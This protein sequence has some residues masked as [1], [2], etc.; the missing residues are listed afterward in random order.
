MWCYHWS[1]QQRKLT[2]R[3]SLALGQESWGLAHPLYVS[4]RVGTFFWRSCDSLNNSKSHLLSIYFTHSTNVY[5]VSIR[6]WAQQWTPQ[7]PQWQRW[8]SQTP[9]SVCCGCCLCPHARASLSHSSPLFLFNFRHAFPTSS[10]TG[11]ISFYFLRAQNQS[12]NIFLFISIRN[13]QVNSNEFK[14]AIAKE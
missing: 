7:S 2:F 13:N 6:C 1:R 5:W 4:E 10:Y 8:A 11:T 9:C 3:S 14:A 12:G